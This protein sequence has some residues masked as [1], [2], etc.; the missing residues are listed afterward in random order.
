[1]VELLI[2]RAYEPAAAEDGM[3]L[4]VDRLW[5]R[6]LSKQALQLDGW[7][8]A[9]APSTG[10]R[11]GW[12][13]DPARFEQFAS[14]YRQELQANAAVDEYLELLAGCPRA[15]LVYAARDQQVNHAVVLRD[16]LRSQLP[17]AP[18]EE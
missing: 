14:A 2:K 7:A 12:N 3:R 16:F 4:L 13:H 17:A 8:K 6:G 11:R 9:L 1:M 15:T 5:P 18:A 10:L